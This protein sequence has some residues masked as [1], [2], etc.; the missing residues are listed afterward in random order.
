MKKILIIGCGQMG[1]RHL[2]SLLAMDLDLEINVIEPQELSIK[3]AKERVKEVNKGK[4]IKNI[5]W[6]CSK[7]DFNGES[8][9]A[10]IATT[11]E[12]R[13]EHIFFALDKEVRFLLV[14]K[15]VAQS[16]YDYQEIMNALKIHN[17]KA[18]VNCTRR[19][20][21]AYQHIKNITKEQ[22]P[23]SIIVQGGN[24]GL[25]SN[26][27]HFIDLLCYLCNEDQSIKLTAQLDKQLFESR[28]ASSI[29]EFSGI[30]NAY[31]SDG[32]HASISF[33]PHSKA[34]CDVLILEKQSRYR[35]FEGEEIAFS[36]HEKENWHLSEY[37]FQS[38]Y[39]SKLTGKIV[40]EIFETYNC[41]LPEVGNLFHIHQSLFNIFNEHIA[42]NSDKKFDYCPIT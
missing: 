38:V 17:A 14:E 10:I 41:L 27:I 24:H 37:L 7:N 21:P 3:I 36:A 28:H 23:V 8:D 22:L 25:G 5:K 18:W 35:I 32:S 26:A 19:Y 40:S 42:N 9:L 6:F 33:L 2:Q 30:I 29:V 1:S 4:G 12:N 15:M 13:K 34:G 16:T 39:T 31:A 11:A 20:F